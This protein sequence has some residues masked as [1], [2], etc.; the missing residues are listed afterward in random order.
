VPFDR[1]NAERAWTSSTK[2]SRYRE[3]APRPFQ[4]K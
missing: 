3:L 2:F 1:V 4:A